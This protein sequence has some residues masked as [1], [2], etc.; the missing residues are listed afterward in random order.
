MANIYFYMFE[1][2]LV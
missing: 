2:S 1:G